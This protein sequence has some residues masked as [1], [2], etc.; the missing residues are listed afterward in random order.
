MKC[1]LN[2]DI[3]VASPPASG[4]F[5]ELKLDLHSYIDLKLGA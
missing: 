2:K 1:R 5:V 4:H 3:G